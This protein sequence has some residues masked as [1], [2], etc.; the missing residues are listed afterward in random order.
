[1]ALL[2][3]H[4]PNARGRARGPGTP[5]SKACKP[6]GWLCGELLHRGTVR[7]AVADLMPEPAAAGREDTAIPELPVTLD[8]PGTDGPGATQ[9]PSRAREPRQHPR[10]I[11][12]TELGL[13]Y[14][15]GVCY[16]AA[17]RYP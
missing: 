8:K 12:R 1:M 11:N 6:G 2:C 16:G 17:S 10:R 14:P 13:P 3:L 7:T 4:P 15:P 9:S 5:T